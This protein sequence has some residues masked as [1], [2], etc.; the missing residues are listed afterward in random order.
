MSY[1]KTPLKYGNTIVDD[2]IPVGIGTTEVL[3]VEDYQPD[4]D[5]L[6][7]KLNDVLD[8]PLGTKPFDNFVKESYQECKK[9]LFMVDDKTRPNIHTKI[10]L[11]LIANRLLRIGIPKEGIGIIIA[12]GSHVLASE[13]EL[14][15]RILGPEIYREWKNNILSHD[16]DAGNRNVGVTSMGCPIL[17][18]EQVLDACMLIPLS[19]SEYHYFAGQ[20]GTVKLFCPGVAGRETIRVNHPRMF[21]LEKG[22]KPTVRLGNTK[23]NPV[24]QEMI[25]IT[26]KMKEKIPIFCVDSIVN[27]GKIVYL[28]AGDII[29]CH[30]AAS[31]PLIRLRVVDVDEPGDLV[32]VSVG[33]LGVNLYQAGKG[34]HAAWNAIRHDKKGW[35]VL[36]ARCEDGIGSAGYEE[37]IK[38]AKDMSVAEGLK[39]VIHEYCNEQ[40]F[41]IGNQKTVDLLRIMLD[42][43]GRNI[44]VITEL[45]SNMLRETYRMEAL[46]PKSP[47][48]VQRILHK[49]VEEYLEVETNPR[50]YVLSD[51]GLLVNVKNRLQV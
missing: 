34:L 30:K 32:F 13:D 9:I 31:E 26:N 29:E 14:E 1:H 10:L 48:D 49:L 4:F 15:F 27:D 42:V 44:K 17:I 33:E 23:G 16:C 51:P 24:I 22:F 41:Q 2:F 11:P 50:I 12:S 18:D 19:D 20:A 3:Q 6:E 5:N 39:F 43:E 25:E 8:N 28:Q 37:A 47:E 7:Q 45:D 38:R 40:T 35:I 36:L 21:D 46:N